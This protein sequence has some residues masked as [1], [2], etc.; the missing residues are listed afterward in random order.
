MQMKHWLPA[1]ALCA[2]I[3]AAPAHA[4]VTEDS[5]LVRT[6]GD[7]LDVCSAP[8]SDPLYTAASN[9]CQGFAVGVYRVLEVQDKAR[10]SGRMFCPSSTPMTRNEGIADFVQWAKAN[11][12]QLAQP[13][14][15]GL[16]R[17]LTQQFP[18]PRGR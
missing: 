7:L 18:C 11:P 14:T 6:T 8:Q 13:A 2:V 1:A 16:A 9:F 15:D 10:R 4:A 12:N 5:F 3:S 17:F